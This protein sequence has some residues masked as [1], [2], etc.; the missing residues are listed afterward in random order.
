ML[1]GTIIRVTLLCC[2]KTAKMFQE[3][4]SLLKVKKKEKEKKS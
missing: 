4:V 2:S 1:T 3:W